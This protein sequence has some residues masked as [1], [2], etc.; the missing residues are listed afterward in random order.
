VILPSLLLLACDERER[1][2]PRPAHPEPDESGLHVNLPELEG[3]GLVDHDGDGW[4]E[5]QDC[6]DHDP[7]RNPDALELCDG[8]DQDC[9]GRGEDD[10]DV[11]GKFACEDCNELDATV[12]FGAE[13]PLDGLDQD[14]DGTDGIGTLADDKVQGGRGDQL[15]TALAVGDLDGDGDAELVAGAVDD[16]Y[17]DANP[18]LWLID[19][20]TPLEASVVVDVYQDNH[21]GSD[22]EIVAPSLLAAVDPNYWGRGAAFVFPV[23]DGLVSA[24]YTARIERDPLF[25]PIVSIEPIGEPVEWWAVGKTSPAEVG[26]FPLDVEGIHAF[27]DA[28][29]LVSSS[30][31]DFATAQNMEA[32]GDRDGDGMHELGVSS[33]YGYPTYEHGI[34]YVITPQLDPILEEAPEIWRGTGPDDLTSSRMDGSHDLDG[35]GVPDLALGSTGFDSWRGALDVV[36]Y[37]G[38][39]DR[40]VEEHSF[41]RLE[42]EQVYDVLGQPA[43]ADLDEDGFADLVVGAFGIVAGWPPGK[44]MWFRGPVQGTLTRADAENVWVGTV[45]GSRFGMALAIAD[46]DGSGALD[47]AIGAPDEIGP[48][49]YSDGAV[50]LVYDAG[51]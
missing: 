36:P 28:T 31:M 34:L 2:R 44:V 41:A 15:G 37:L 39:G 8:I 38:P 43:A 14:C 33:P 9:D 20:G 25:S 46:I 18:S 6:D 45:P 23:A 24:D 11:D 50:Y 21:L 27:E 3:R 26:L 10:L 49:G 51:L 1:Q 4:F 40:V 29:W 32:L 12:Y 35:D 30:D 5:P 47:L 22:V 13:D 16:V 7:G 17:L 19:Y 48:S 42:G